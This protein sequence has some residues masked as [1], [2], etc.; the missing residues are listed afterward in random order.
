M[1]PNNPREGEDI[2]PQRRRPESRYPGAT[3]R[4]SSSWTVIAR[5]VLS[6]TWRGEANS[7]LWIVGSQG[8]WG[9]TPGAKVAL[10]RPSY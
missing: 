10:L 3:E 5:V 9:K 6:A 2:A 4:S 1:V 7:F 8:I